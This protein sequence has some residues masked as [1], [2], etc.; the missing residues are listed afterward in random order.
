MTGQEVREAC[1]PD[2]YDRAGWEDDEEHGRRL[3]V[4]G[5]TAQGRRL[6]IVLQPID[7]HEGIW[8]LRT[9]L[10]PGQRGGIAAAS[11][12]RH[13]GFMPCDEDEFAEFEMDEAE[14]DA[15][16]EAAE[17]AELIARPV[18]PTVTARTAHGTFKVTMPPLVSVSIGEADSEPAPEPAVGAG[19]RLAV[20]RV[21]IPA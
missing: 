2:A 18:R 8:R 7:V 20:H 17:P 10:L 3:L 13:D 14:F 4:E 5:R 6:K 12:V 19:A 9:V 15:R 21:R 11:A 16:M 1:V